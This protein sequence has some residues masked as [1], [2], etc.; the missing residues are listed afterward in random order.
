MTNTMKTVLLS[1]SGTFLVLAG[2]GSMIQPDPGETGPR[3]A[4]ARPAPQPAAQVT[5]RE[6]ACDSTACRE[7]SDGRL[8]MQIPVMRDTDLN[9]AWME[10]GGTP[11]RWYPKEE[12]DR[13]ARRALGIVAGTLRRTREQTW[14]DILGPTPYRY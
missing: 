13:I 10:A 6:Y 1:A 8:E 11:G 7:Y 2:I 5:F 4:R 14:R 3:I 12:Y 9:I